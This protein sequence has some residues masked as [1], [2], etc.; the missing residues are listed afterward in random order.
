M[1]MLRGFWDAALVI[2]PDAA[3]EA[4]TMRFGRQGEIAQLF[5]TAGLGDI[6]ES[7]LHVS[8]TYTSFDEMWEGFLAGVG[9]AGSFCVALGDEDRHRLRGELFRRFGSPGGSFTLGAV[10]RC[11]VA[12]VVA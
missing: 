2:D 1:E 5:A 4:R 6:V 11:A 9:P 8:S 3:D 10:A 7:T 12:R